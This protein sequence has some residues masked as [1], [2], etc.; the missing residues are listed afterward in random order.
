VQVSKNTPSF[1]LQ[2]DI[3]SVRD[4]AAAYDIKKWKDDE[5]EA[6]G[7]IVRERG[8]YTKD[9]FLRV[10]RWKSPRTNPR[11]DENQ[12]DFVSAATATAL[13]TPDEQLRIEVLTLLRGVSWPT[14]SVLLHFGHRE[15]YPILDF[16]A[17]WS[18]GIDPP[19]PEYTFEFWWDYSVCCRSM[20]DEAGVNMRTLDR[21]LWQH[22]KKN[23]GPD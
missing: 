15:R 3:A 1:R 2:F 11:C 12:P 19:P 21:A 9:E 20:A 6:M 14:A 23:Q 7:R 8:H 16:R 22:S 5:V 10:C 13:A 17:L 4:L 18:L